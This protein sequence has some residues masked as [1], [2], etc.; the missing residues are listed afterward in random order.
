VSKDEATEEV[1]PENP[2]ANQ[3]ARTWYRKNVRP[4]LNEAGEYDN[5]ARAYQ[6]ELGDDE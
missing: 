2:V 5:S 1:Y 6:L 3:D 4:V